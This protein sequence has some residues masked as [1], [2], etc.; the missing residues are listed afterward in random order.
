MRPNT[1]KLTVVLST[2]NPS[3]L[4]A[5]STESL[6]AAI[7]A[8]LS[9]VANNYHR[10]LGIDETL[11]DIIGYLY[12]NRSETE[13]LRLLQDAFVAY[14]RLSDL[15]VGLDRA[16]VI[17]Y[18]LK[19]TPD[20]LFVTLY[21]YGELRNVCYAPREYHHSSGFLTANLPATLSH[22]AYR[23]LPAR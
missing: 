21:G 6:L 22:Y 4:G 14:M 8:W 18:T 11:A 5:G 9:P 3:F 16:Q 19:Q 7:Y 1:H 10:F 20:S 17:D 13:T 23:R 2:D 12:I 15:L